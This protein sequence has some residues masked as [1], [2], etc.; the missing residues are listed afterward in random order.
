MCRIGAIKSNEYF[1]PVKTL[2]LMRSQ[3]KGHDNS[4]FGFVME[5]LR[6]IF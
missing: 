2:E 1:H 6:R 3:Q 5:D 4:C